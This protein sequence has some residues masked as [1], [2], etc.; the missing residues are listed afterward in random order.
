MCSLLLTYQLQGFPEDYSA[1]L[2]LVRHLEVLGLIYIILAIVY[3]FQIST[4]GSERLSEVY[5]FAFKAVKLFPWES[6]AY[7]H[8]MKYFKT[9]WLL[10]IE[11]V[12]GRLNEQKK[13][14]SSRVVCGQRWKTPVWKKQ[15]TSYSLHHANSLTR[16]T[17]DRWALTVNEL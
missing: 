5:F 3:I 10:A 16:G 14:K 6:L 9:L 15:S 12:S 17:T 2:V 4:S 1:A 7:S 11:Q 8:L 13:M